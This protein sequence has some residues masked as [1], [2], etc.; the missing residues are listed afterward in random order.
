M[1]VG[2][3]YMGAFS[4]KY[5]F[6]DNVPTQGLITI[7]RLGHLSWELVRTKRK[8]ETEGTIHSYF[9]L[10]FETDNLL[11]DSPIMFTL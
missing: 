8:N 9:D 6:R 10:S 4:I 5:I 1:I 11:V 7:V 3:R 2:L